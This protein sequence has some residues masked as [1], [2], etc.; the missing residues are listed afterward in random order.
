[1]TAQ[2]LEL[3]RR[4]EQL[5]LGV[6]R[7][8]GMT[9]LARNWRCR[10]GELDAVGLDG[11]QLVVVEVKTR[12]SLR[13]GSAAEAV[14]DAKVKRL[15]ELGWRFQREHGLPIEQIRVDVVAIDF[16]EGSPLVRYFRGVWV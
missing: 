5:A 9:I 14:S 15:Y 8:R 10:N 16:A 2:R 13:Y 4:G 1:M 12:S 6:L 11:E 7:D 3:G